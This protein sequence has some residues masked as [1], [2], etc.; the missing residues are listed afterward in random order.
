MYFFR[1]GEDVENFFVKVLEHY[2]KVKELGRVYLAGHSYGGYH[3]L[4]FAYRFS[5]PSYAKL[6]FVY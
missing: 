6:L 4:N 5:I 3:A 2:I 1:T